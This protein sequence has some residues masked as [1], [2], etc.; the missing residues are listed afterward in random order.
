LLSVVKRG[1]GQDAIVN[2]ERSR[3][4]D[5]LVHE[6]TVV[7]IGSLEVHVMQRRGDVE[8]L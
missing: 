4:V 5:G 8:V 1:S 3:H 2:V 6:K 7:G